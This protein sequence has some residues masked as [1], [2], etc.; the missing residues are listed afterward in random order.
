MVRIGSITVE[1]VHLHFVQLIIIYNCSLNLIIFQSIGAV[2]YFKTVIQSKFRN[3]KLNESSWSFSSSFLGWFMVRNECKKKKKIIA[4]ATITSFGI[5]ERYFSESSHTQWKFTLLDKV[6]NSRLNSESVEV[7]VIE[8]FTREL[9][10]NW[11]EHLKVLACFHC[12]F[13]QFLSFFFF[14]WLLIL[15]ST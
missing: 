6:Q 13:F 15:W 12:S 5:Y 8:M 14:I 11:A 1:K 2:I 10:V 3:N 7:Y 4:H 9:R